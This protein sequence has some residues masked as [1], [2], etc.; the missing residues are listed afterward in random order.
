MRDK[1]LPYN[2]N[3]HFYGTGVDCNHF[4][5]V[6]TEDLEVDAEIAALRTLVRYRAELIQHRAPH[7]LHMQRVLQQMNL[8]L[9]Q[10]MLY[11]YQWSQT[12]NVFSIIQHP[13]WLDIV[14]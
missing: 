11:F 9:Q 10:S 5:R 8:Q 2:A 6:L 1:R 4:G 12:R 7:I 3:A 13:F 14:K